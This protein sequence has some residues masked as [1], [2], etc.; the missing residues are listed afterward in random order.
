MKILFLTAHYP[1][2]TKGGG[3]ISTHLLAKALV[4]LG[5]DIT[6]VTDGDALTDT[7]DDVKV[8]R[9]P[10]GL[11]KK[12]LFER[13][14]A[15]ACAVA[16][17]HTIDPQTFDVIHA[18]DFRSGLAL[19]EM[20]RARII[21]AK[22]AIVTVRDY[23]YISG[24]S[25]N[26]LND[27]T[28]PD[29]PS[30]LASSWH[31]QRVAEINWLRK[32]G[33]FAQYALNVPYRTAALSRLPYRIYISN[34]QWQVIRKHVALPKL[35]KVIYN[36][37]AE[38]YLVQPI[39]PVRSNAVLYVGRIEKYKGVGQLLKAWQTISRHD[40]SARLSL[41]GTGAQLAHYLA[42]AKRLDIAE[43]VE[44]KEH[45]PYEE[46]R[47][48]YDEHTILV[49]PN[50]WLEPFG[51]VVV[52]AMARAR[53]VVASKAGGPGE[54]IIP[55]ITGLLYERKSTGEL[56][57]R[58]LEALNLPA[59]DRVRI[60]EAAREWVQRTLDPSETAKQYDQFYS[61]IVA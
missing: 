11:R 61:D 34:A 58:L 20:V 16:I 7:V 31:S 9:R 42:M 49:A 45:V 33:R 17:S 37:V 14:A 36:P 25:N 41:V 44:F 27:G 47:Q 8:I 54:I 22:K 24:D 43:N 48:L 5:H 32:I 6:V 56:T 4:R 46:M 10:L 1:P 15:A 30:S 3:E 12:P 40:Q 18:H 57:A 21:P 53:L 26:V 13:W 35:A 59:T 50:V 55:G 23:A 39:V 38:D 28:I 51:R 29:N 60:G 19:S 52:E 2:Q